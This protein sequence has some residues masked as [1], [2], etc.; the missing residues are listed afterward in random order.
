MLS[1]TKPN[2]YPA[3]PISN[4][5][6]SPIVPG[7]GSRGNNLFCAKINMINKKKKTLVL[8]LPPGRRAF[9][10]T[11]LANS[12]LFNLSEW[13]RL[14]DLPSGSLRHIRTGSRVATHEQYVN[15]QKTILPKLCEMVFTL[16]NYPDP[17]DL[18]HRT[19]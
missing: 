10:A 6:R 3:G 18:N 5:A 17:G 4:L 14:C 7:L 15:L 2:L 11:L 16:Q 12:K 1:P 13:E 19:Y 9:E 8:E